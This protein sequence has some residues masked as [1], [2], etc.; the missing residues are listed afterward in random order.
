MNQSLL[1]LTAATQAMILH[2]NHCCRIDL[3][4]CDLRRGLRLRLRAQPT[5]CAFKR[6]QEGA[7]RQYRHSFA[8]AHLRR[9]AALHLPHAGNK[10]GSARSRNRG[11][12][13]RSATEA[14]PRAVRASYPHP[15]HRVPPGSIAP[16]RTDLPAGSR[17]APALTRCAGVV[18]GSSP[19]PVRDHVGTDA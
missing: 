4:F 2:G 13:I 9:V 5:P 14:P 12:V 10:A 8:L 17:C 3:T 11:R 18:I 1:A 15:S 16:G 7:A 19:P 6:T